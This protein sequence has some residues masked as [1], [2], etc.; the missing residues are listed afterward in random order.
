MSATP[1]ARGS[2]IHLASADSRRATPRSSAETRSTAELLKELRR[3]FPDMPLAERIA[4]LA[5]AEARS[6]PEIGLPHPVVGKQF[7]AGAGQRDAAVLQHIGAARELERHRDVL[8][9]QHAG[10]PLPVEVADGLPAPAARRS[11]R[12]RATARRTSRAP[13]RPSG[14]ARSPASAARRPTACRPP[15]RSARSSTREHRQHAIEVLLLAGARPRQHRAHFEVL[16]DGERREHLAA[17]RDLPDAEI[18][19]AVRRQAGDV[20]AAQ[21][22][23]AARRPVHAG[24]GADQRG[25]AGAVGADDGDDRALRRRRAR[26]RRAPA[27]RHGTR[28]GSRRRA[29]SSASA[30]R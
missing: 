15:G 12:A 20:G 23:A 24:D 9:D 10:Q 19:D 26:R 28:R 8:L 3:T 6:H 1:T 16:G 2:E 14:S 4:A 22:D 7:R 18:A 30:P 13:A 27:R 25:L 17:F 11:A 29:S 21:H 5:D